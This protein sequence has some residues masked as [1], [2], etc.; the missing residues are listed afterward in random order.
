MNVTQLVLAFIDGMLLA[1]FLDALGVT[2]AL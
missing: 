1:A 2:G